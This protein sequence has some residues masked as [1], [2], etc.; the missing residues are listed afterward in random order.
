MNLSC[1]SSPLAIP[2]RL[3]PAAAISKSQVELMMLVYICIELA[4]QICPVLSVQAPSIMSKE[5]F[6]ISD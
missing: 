1:P 6:R 3:D 2:T 5:H 4:P